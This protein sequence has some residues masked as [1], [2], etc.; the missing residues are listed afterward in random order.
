MMASLELCCFHTAMNCL[1]WHK[2]TDNTDFLPGFFQGAKSLVLQI[3][4]VMPV[5]L[6]FSDFFLGGGR[7][8]RSQNTLKV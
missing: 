6:L 2:L 4:I 7:K 5:S 1:A 8:E 3:S